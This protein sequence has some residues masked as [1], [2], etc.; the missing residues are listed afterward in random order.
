M[1]SG[2]NTSKLEHCSCENIYVNWISSPIYSYFSFAVSFFKGTLYKLYSPMATLFK[3]QYVQ[4][5][6]VMKCHAVF[7]QL[8]KKGDIKDPLGI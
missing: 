6:G 7:T 4:W 2:S 1:V 5:E 8:I 3:G